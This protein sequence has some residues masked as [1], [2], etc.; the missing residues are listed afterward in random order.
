[1]TPAEA[2]T[3]RI[4]IAALTKRAEA[5]EQRAN[6]AEAERDHLRALLGRLRTSLAEVHND[7]MVGS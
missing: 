2:E 4:E 6:R 7:P 3:V 1:M 5:A